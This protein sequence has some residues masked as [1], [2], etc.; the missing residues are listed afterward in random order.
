MAYA[1]VG[2]A[3]IS[4]ANKSHASGSTTIS[5][6]LGK[7]AHR[8]QPYPEM[9]RALGPLQ[10]CSSSRRTSCLSGSSIQNP[11]QE[12]VPINI[13]AIGRVLLSPEISRS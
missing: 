7:G 6:G 1:A 5:V 10:P 8:L 3:M 9:C 2:A 11:W 4:E 12:A 13:F